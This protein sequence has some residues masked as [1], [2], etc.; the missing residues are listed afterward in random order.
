M[1][2]SCGLA[3]TTRDSISFHDKYAWIMFENFTGHFVSFELANGGY[4][5]GSL[6]KLVSFVAILCFLCC[7]FI[8]GR[9]DLSLYPIPIYAFLAAQLLPRYI[10][11]EFYPPSPFLMYIIIE[12]L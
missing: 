12:N 11:H 8:F 9:V 7:C 6:H 2:I 4:H 1:R 3:G 5:M 10:A